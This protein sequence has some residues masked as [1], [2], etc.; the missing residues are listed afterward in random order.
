MTA[1][2]TVETNT[3]MFTD[4][5]GSTRLLQ[6]LGDRY[7]QVLD[8]QRRLIST[9]V[10][11]HGGRVFGSEGD[12]LFAA[13]PSA[14][15]AVAAAAE[16]QRSLAGHA[17]PSVTPLRVRMGIHTGEAMAAGD[18]FV[19]LALHEVARIMAA[20]HGGQVLVSEATRR[21]A[22]S[23]P[24]G[25]E[26]RDLGERRLKDLAAPERL[27]QLVSEGLADKF[28]PLR[29][30]DARNNNLPVQVTSFIGRAE[31]AA[32]R[33]AL[34]ETRLLTLTGPGG[35]GKTRLALQLAGD[36]S[37]QFTD[38]VFFVPLDAITDPMLLASQIASSI[39]LTLSGTGSPADAVIGYLRD[40][41]ALLLLDNFEQIIEAATEVGRLVREAPGI[42]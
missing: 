33:A 29:T 38:G 11:N 6:E 27:Y 34:A 40:R 14:V 26:L 7:P 23:L 8:D 21:V 13:F 10:E 36:V 31:L 35:T 1:Q 19:G 4:I 16:S 32:A 3:F 2:R 17:W 41:Q 42:K 22:Q 9:A 25:L 5:E 20:G 30:L 28:P 37:D 39:G 18:N 24:H 15:G 12:A